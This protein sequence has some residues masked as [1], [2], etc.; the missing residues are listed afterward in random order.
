MSCFYGLEGGAITVNGLKCYPKMG[1]PWGSDAA[2]YHQQDYKADCV[3]TFQNPWPMN[4]NLL[5]K[6]KNWIAYVP[7]EFDPPN[8]H[9]IERLSKAY[10]LISL[11]KFG[12]KALKNVGL[13]SELILEA[14]DTKIFKPMDKKVLRK[15]MGIPQEDF[16]FGMVAANKDNPPR[17][18]FQHC[19]DAFAKFHKEHPKSAMYFHV[20]LQQDGGFP[21]QDYAKHLG[22]SKKI[23]FTP[24][25]N[26]MFKSP[27]PVI[28][29]IMNTFDVLLNPSSGEGFGLP[30]I[31]AQSCGIPVVVNDWTCYDENTRLLTENG[32]KGFDEV[33]VGE[34]VWTLDG[35]KLS[36]QPIKKK[37]QY[38]FD[39]EMVRFKNKRVDLLVTPNHRMYY[40]KKHRENDNYY[41]VK[42]AEEFVDNTQTL[43]MLPI[44]GK[45]QTNKN[46][47][48]IEN[49]DLNTSS[50]KINI[51]LKALLNIL[52][53]YISEGCLSKDKTQRYN[54]IRF[55][56]TQL[57][58]LNEIIN[59]LKTLGVKGSKQ[60]NTF[61]GI[62]AYSIDLANILKD[63]GTSSYTKRIPK[64]FLN[65]KKEYLIELFN[66]LMKGDGSKEGL[67]GR[68]ISY[69]T[70]SKQLRD[71][72]VELTLKL[73]FSPKTY[74][75]KPQL[76]GKIKG[77]T[78]KSKGSWK[79][80]VRRKA[81]GLIRKNQ[82]KKQNYKGKVWCVETPTGNLFVERNGQFICSGNSMPELVLPGKTG[83]ICKHGYKQWNNMK[84][85]SAMPD[86]DS[87]YEKMEMVYKYGRDET[88]KKACRTHIVENYDMEDRV[89][90]AWIPFLCKIQDELLGLP[91]GVK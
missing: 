47:V 14:V 10:R 80:S 89:K 77:R 15:E 17:K 50:K 60:N 78:I 48:D 12:H 46:L 31:E 81:R 3:I 38:D 56:N 49:I 13:Q 18:A 45:W 11:S 51:N 85:F 73:G 29:K 62:K 1:Q 2:F 63:C 59:N 90:N 68:Y 75:R 66:S 37:H 22:I 83:E 74:Y 36:L 20:L 86:L 26:M 58:N 7:I 67:D 79:I 87:L 43:S 6:I 32:I 8:V 88:T 70:S 33:K 34:L 19:M 28:S 9:N 35:E 16:L 72:F 25:Y 5:F 27:H 40:K 24:P 69:I 41:E 55:S 57:E 76:S 23:F 4:P 21:I 54:C 30:I 61:K 84:T 82:I 65:L 42:K 44:T 52:G 71:D 53:W 64:K 91:K 39:G